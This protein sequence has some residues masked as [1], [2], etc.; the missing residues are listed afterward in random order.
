MRHSCF[1]HESGYETN[2]SGIGRAAKCQSLTQHTKFRMSKPDRLGLQ[3]FDELEHII[4]LDLELT[5]WEESV[6]TNWAD[7]TRPPEVLEIGLALLDLP[8][9]QVVNTFSSLAKPKVNPRLSDY[10]KSLLK[11]TQEEIDRAQPLPEVVARVIRWDAQL[12]LPDTPTGAWGTLDRLW[13]HAD[14]HRCNSTDP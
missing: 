6:K 10:C 3:Q 14:A 13:L 2:G 7:P 8:S 11:I 1:L 9:G 5:C 4:L 12:G